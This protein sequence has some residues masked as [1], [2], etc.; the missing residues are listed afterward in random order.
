[1]CIYV[2]EC[3]CVCVCVCVCV[4]LHSTVWTSRP[5]SLHVDSDV[6]VGVSR[7]M[8]KGMQGPGDEVGIGNYKSWF[9]C[10]RAAS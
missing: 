6:Y 9:L 5:T 1:V 10:T 3:E 8:K 7:G 4:A 2:C